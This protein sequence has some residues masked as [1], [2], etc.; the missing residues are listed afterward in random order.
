MK[1]KLSKIANATILSRKDQKKI[2]GGFFGGS[3]ECMV[4]GCDHGRGFVGFEGGPCGLESPADEVCIGIV[5]NGKCC[6]GSF[7]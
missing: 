4:T 6:I 7:N 5:R 1:T 2:K 3:T